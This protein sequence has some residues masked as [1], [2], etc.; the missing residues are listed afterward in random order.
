MSRI[1]TMRVHQRK[2]AIW[3]LVGVG[4]RGSRRG[5][6]SSSLRRDDIPAGLRRTR[7]AG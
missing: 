7:P 2:V 6:R 5:E 4:V 1:L 3:L